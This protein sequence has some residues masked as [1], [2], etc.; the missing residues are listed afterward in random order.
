M[1]EK[2]RKVEEL[3]SEICGTI[4]KQLQENGDLKQ[5]IAELQRYQDELSQLEAYLRTHMH[6]ASPPPNTPLLQ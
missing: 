3:E 2:S 5:R 1:D 4:E 6:Q